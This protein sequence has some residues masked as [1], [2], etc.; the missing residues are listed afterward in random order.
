MSHLNIP[1]FVCDAIFNRCTVE[2][3]ICTRERSLPEYR[4]GF[5]LS[6]NP[7]VYASKCLALA[8]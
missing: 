6:L 3:I 4:P 2:Q 7:R 8:R 5:R 1:L